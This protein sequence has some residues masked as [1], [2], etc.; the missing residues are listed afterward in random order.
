MKLFTKSI[1]LTFL[2]LI[3]GLC[4]SA[5][6]FS[7]AG[8]Y[9]FN[10][11]GGKTAGGSVIFIEHTLDITE[12]NGKLDAHFFSNGFQTARDVYADGKIVGDKLLLYYRDEGEENFT[13]DYKKGEL[14]LTLE[15]KR[16]GKT[17][18]LLTYWSAFY[19]VIETNE[20]DGRV[21]FVRDKSKK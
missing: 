13:S 12:K 15:R 17:T 16:V 2:I 21:Y 20:K 4:V 1:S 14:L 8:K 3:F 7:W 11:S 19:P 5:Q 18:K 6:T 10:E 9:K